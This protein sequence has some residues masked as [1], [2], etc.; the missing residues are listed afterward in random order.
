MK[1]ETLVFLDD[2]FS[3]V[4]EVFKKNSPEHNHILS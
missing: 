1:D 2:C 4:C 3:N